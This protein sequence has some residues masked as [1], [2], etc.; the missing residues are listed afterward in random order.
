MGMDLPDLHIFTYQSTSTQFPISQQHIINYLNLLYEYF[1][2][3]QPECKPKQLTS[4]GKF[5]A[6]VESLSLSSL[7]RQ[8]VLSGILIA[9]F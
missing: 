2:V 5:N 6:S 8:V 1:I 4:K 9:Q 7:Y 3:R